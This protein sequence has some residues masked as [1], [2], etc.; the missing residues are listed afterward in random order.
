MQKVVFSLMILDVDSAGCKAKDQVIPPRPPSLP[1]SPH[2]GL[3]DS[4]P[5]VF[6][7]EPMTYKVSPLPVDVLLF[8]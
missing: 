6:Q 3:A 7:I 2:V 8:F 4:F 5:A 1:G